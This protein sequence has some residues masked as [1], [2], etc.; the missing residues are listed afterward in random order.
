MNTVLPKWVHWLLLYR[1]LKVMNRPRH[2]QLNQVSH[3]SV[4]ISMQIS[5]S[6]ACC[7]A[8]QL[9]LPST[10]HL[11]FSSVSPTLPTLATISCW[12][13]DNRKGWSSPRIYRA[14]R[15]FNLIVSINFEK[16]VSI[17]NWPL[18]NLSDWLFSWSS[19]IEDWGWH[20]LVVIKAR[21]SHEFI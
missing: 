7:N 4:F 19:Q 18:P 1:P 15:T 10:F 6:I 11:F 12:L 3:S 2:V 16:S 8:S 5:F 21:R 13:N 9:L 20:I 14:F 17:R